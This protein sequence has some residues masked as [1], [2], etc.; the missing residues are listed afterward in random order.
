[1]KPSS[2]VP[3]LIAGLLGGT[4]G[5][6]AVLFGSGPPRA[7]AD[8]GPAAAVLASAPASAD[9]AAPD[10]DRQDRFEREQRRQ[11][12]VLRALHAELGALRAA[13]ASA[14]QSRSDPAVAPLPS[15]DA[16]EALVIEVVQR[17]REAAAAEAT[18]RNQAQVAETAALSEGPYG[19]YNYRVN[20]MSRDLDLRP[21]QE[22]AYYELLTDFATRADALQ[23][24]LQQ[25]L[26]WDGVGVE[27]TQQ[28]IHQMLARSAAL[29]AEM[30]QALTA[31]LDPAQRQRFEALPPDRRGL[32]NPL[33][34]AASDF[35]PR[36]R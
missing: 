5:A 21:D 24:Q 34:I 3:V 7:D 6:S 25:E 4:V 1:M 8:T 26:A 17:E 31:L 2:I 16:L 14:S 28:R 29:D 20:R 13:V 11:A 30:E 19:A 18:R 15:T 35:E 33:A 36:P 9:R 23:G 12:D 10:T 27:E 22:T 32:G